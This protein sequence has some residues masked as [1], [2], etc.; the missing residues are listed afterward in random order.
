MFNSRHIG[1]NKLDDAYLAVVPTGTGTVRLYSALQVDF[2]KSRTLCVISRS[3]SMEY[4]ADV[5]CSITM[6][7][8]TEGSCYGMLC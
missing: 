7:H 5:T 1:E 2:A 8:N 4:Y 3:Q 6:T